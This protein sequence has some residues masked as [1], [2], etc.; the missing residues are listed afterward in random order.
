MI[1]ESITDFYDSGGELLLNT[2]NVIAD[3]MI[4]PDDDEV[5]ITIK[6]LLNTRIRPAV[7]VRLVGR[8]AF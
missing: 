3:T 7:Q 5:V 6:E 4:M 8:V 1:F 2:D